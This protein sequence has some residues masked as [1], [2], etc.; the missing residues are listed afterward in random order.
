MPIHQNWTFVDEDKFTSVSVWVPLCD[1]SRFNGTL[2]VVPKTH[3][4]LTKYRSP[5]IPWV[6]AEPVDVVVPFEGH[7]VESGKWLAVVPG[8]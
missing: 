4:T 1:V 6:F 3:N 2:E 5:S 8:G 7:V